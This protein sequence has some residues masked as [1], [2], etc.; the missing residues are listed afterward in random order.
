M[1]RSTHRAIPMTVL[2]LLGASS[3]STSV[4]DCLRL[5][6]SNDPGQQ[7]AFTLTFAPEFGGTRTANIT[8]SEILLEVCSDTGQARFIDYYQE[9]EPLTLPDG[10]STGDLTILIDDSQSVSFAPATG[11]FE[12]N[13]LYAIHF[14]GDLSAYQ[15]GSPFVLPDNSVG[16]VNFETPSSG[17][18][19][20]DWTGGA[21]LP[22]PFV[23]GEF[24]P[25]TY[26]C[27]VNARFTVQTPCANAAVGCSAG[28]VD[29]NCQ[30]DLTDLGHT[31]ASFGSSGARIRPSHGDLDRDRDVDLTDL[32]R[33]L[34][35]F[36]N[37]CN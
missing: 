33:L 36:G 10:A 23:P 6:A 2:G 8:S 5:A 11:I 9:G 16:T 22:N 13:D 27:V 28:D 29:G 26:A 1:S 4:A 18:I 12:T 30:V 37:N 32:A 34:A 14:T 7:N 21:A 20:M 25:F 19:N 31:L 24:I 3:A 17:T 15:I 35:E